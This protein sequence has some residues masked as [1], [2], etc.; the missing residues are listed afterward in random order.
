MSILLSLLL[1]ITIITTQIF[2]SS[3]SHDDWKFLHAYPKHVMVRRVPDGSVAIDG[4]VNDNEWT[5][6]DWHDNDFEDIT[7][8]KNQTDLN[9]VPLY[10]HASVAVL[11]DSKYLMSVLR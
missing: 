9:H 10:Q 3:S 8:H 4:H 5:E 7:F 11:Y 1:I 6:A 2:G